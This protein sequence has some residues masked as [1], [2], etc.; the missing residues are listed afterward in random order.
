[1]KKKHEQATEPP[2]DAHAVALRLG[3]SVFTVK[4]E[5]RRGAL[6]FYRIGA[7]K[8]RLRFSEEHVQTYLDRRENK[9]H[10]VTA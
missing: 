1:M 3:V 8:G 9:Q 4:R 6:G 7:G 5:T 2:L 10:H